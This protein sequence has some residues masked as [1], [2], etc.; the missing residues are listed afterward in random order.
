ME[1]MSD[2]DYFT[3]LSLSR[4]AV[5]KARMARMFQTTDAWI[6]FCLPY[7]ADVNPRDVAFAK[8]HATT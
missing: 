7:G 8:R 5:Q 6:L 2:R 1:G 3:S 4:E